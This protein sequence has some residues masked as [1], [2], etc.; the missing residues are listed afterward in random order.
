MHGRG[1]AM[2]A[3][4]VAA[5]VA[6]SLVGCGG[7]A[8]GQAS[9][10]RATTAASATAGRVAGLST[11]AFS[12]PAAHSMRGLK[13]DEDDDDPESKTEGQNPIVDE[14][15]DQDNDR[16][17]N[18]GLG[19][20]D[21]DDTPVRAYGHAASAAQA[22]VLLAA[23]GEYARAAAAEDGVRACELLAPEIAQLALLYGQPGGT[24]Y[25]RGASTCPQV[26][27]RQFAHLHG[28]LDGP[29]YAV[30]ERVSGHRA[31]V[32]VG[33]RVAPASAYPLLLLQG[34]WRVEELL[35]RQQP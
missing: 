10:S 4:A 20:Y 9:R 24:P 14:D 18:R 1:S 17:D 8:G 11:P 3:P 35:P 26:M 25:L 19:Y 16:L 13:G 32:L 22:R 21:R 29:L 33:S 2:L 23:V 5:A 7:S 30:S 31:K 27:A 34:R 12:F 15:A 28:E 6:L